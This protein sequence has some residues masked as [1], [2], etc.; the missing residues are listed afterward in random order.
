LPKNEALERDD[1]V[2]ASSSRSTSF[3]KHDPRSKGAFRPIFAG[4]AG[5]KPFPKTGI[6]ARLHE[7]ML[8]GITF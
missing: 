7:G 2:F 6:H 1:F 4:D 8:F 3:A 5:G